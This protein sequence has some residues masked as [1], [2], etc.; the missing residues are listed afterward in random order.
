[1]TTEENKNSVAASPDQ[2][3]EDRAVQ[4]AVTDG[5]D[6]SDQDVDMDVVATE[7][8]TVS[9]DK[10]ATVSPLTMERL[11]STMGQLEKRIAELDAKLAKSDKAS[12][13]VP[14]AD[15]SKADYVNGDNEQMARDRKKAMDSVKNWETKF[16]SA[17][18]TT[19]PFD[20]WR[21]ELISAAGVLPWTGQDARSLVRTSLTGSAM[22]YFTWSCQIKEKEDKVDMSKQTLDDFI[23]LM[24]DKYTN[25]NAI[26]VQVQDFLFLRPKSSKAVETLEAHLR[27]LI[28]SLLS[29]DIARTLMLGKLGREDQAMADQIRALNL[30]YTQTM[31]RIQETWRSREVASKRSANSDSNPKSHKKM[32]LG[33][34]KNVKITCFGCGETG[35]KKNECPNKNQDRKKV[36]ADTNKQ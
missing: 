4:V 20:T 8:N 15:G 31:A 16:D 12:T 27:N 10:T 22:G 17:T 2:V 1:M 7:Q 5:V 13:V 26:D 18:M 11:T 34:A 3:Q 14:K 25:A 35:H 36:K 23:K 24:A 21:N 32:K 29:E 28:P 6:T 9:Q 30:N 19:F 33:G